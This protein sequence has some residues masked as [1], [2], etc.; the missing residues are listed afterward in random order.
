VSSLCLGIE[1]QGLSGQPAMCWFFFLFM[2]V[3]AC[4]LSLQFQCE[5]VEQ[6]NC[7]GDSNPT[8]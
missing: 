6:C 7:R 3:G 5:Y 1:I 2:C 8:V 4:D